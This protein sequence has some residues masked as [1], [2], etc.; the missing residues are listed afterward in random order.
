MA[1]ASAGARGKGGR[2][3]LGAREISNR[4][5]QA[6]RPQSLWKLVS[7]GFRQRIL[8]RVSCLQKLRDFHHFSA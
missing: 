1:S 6:H 5:C 4:L 8:F 3:H 7:T 2:A